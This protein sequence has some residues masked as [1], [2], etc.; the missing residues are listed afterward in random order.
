MVEDKTLLFQVEDRSAG[1][2]LDLLI[3][4]FVPD[5]S[6]NGVQNMIRD[7][8]ITVNDRPATKR[9][10]ARVRDRLKVTLPPPVVTAFQPENIPLTIL[11]EDDEIIAVDKPS[12]MVVHPAP[13]HRKGTLVNALLYRSQAL[14]AVGGDSRPGI[15]HRLDKDT[16]GVVLVAKNNRAHRRLSTQFALR[17]VD[18]TYLAVASGHLRSE[19]GRWETA[20]GRD[21][22]ERKKISSRSSRP[23]PAATRNRLILRLEGAS[24]LELHPETGRTHQIRVHLAE[25][26]HPV[27]GDPVYGPKWRRRSP[28]H[29]A[30]RHYGFADRLAL[31]ARRISF[32]H[33]SSDSPLEI[34]A[35]LPPEFE[36]ITPS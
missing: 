11:F 7:G 9:Y 30:S 35:P 15:V 16:S 2:R 26:G 4:Q 33:P 17:Q 36:R 31:H 5:L 23:R 24:L 8:L 6:R 3:P 20:I 27:L 22:K 21:R 13:G 28:Y 12:G 10:L 1:V 25:N 34:E 29:E 18:K 32:R 19:E 14:S